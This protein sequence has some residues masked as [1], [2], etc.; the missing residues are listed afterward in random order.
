MATKVRAKFCCTEKTEY[1]SSG[2]KFVFEPRY[3]ESIPE[4][5]RFA[6]SSPS[7]KFEIYV[8]NPSVNFAA[9]APYYIDITPV[10]E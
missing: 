9:G 4:D 1:G 6:K 3:D 2:R 8:D 7:G 10:I 5:Q